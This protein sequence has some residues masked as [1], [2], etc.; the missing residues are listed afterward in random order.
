ML[1]PQCCR[2]IFGS[3]FSDKVYFQFP[4]NEFTCEVF[5]QYTSLITIGHICFFA[6]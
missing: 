1:L 4:H 3:Q 5:A 2:N 6:F